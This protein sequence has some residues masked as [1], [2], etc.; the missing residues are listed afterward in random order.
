LT[1]LP[2]QYKYF[3]IAWD[4]VSEDLKAI[5]NLFG[6]LQLE[7]SKIRN[8]EKQ[9]N[10]SF[11]VEDKYKGENKNRYKS[12]K[13]YRCDSFGHVRAQCKNT[14][15]NEHCKKDNHE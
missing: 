5:A 14:F 11:K 7:E 10:I 9:E 12:I 15:K 8:T 3:S 1:I 2:E 6:R 4:S 13:C